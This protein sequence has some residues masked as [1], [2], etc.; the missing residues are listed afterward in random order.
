MRHGG[1]TEL[2]GPGTIRE[3]PRRLLPLV[4][5]SGRHDAWWKSRGVEEPEQTRLLIFG[6]TPDHSLKVARLVRASYLVA[7]GFSPA[8]PSVTH[9]T[10]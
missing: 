6:I 2:R 5:S 7:R 1:S 4:L 3:L 10:W 9:L 8:L